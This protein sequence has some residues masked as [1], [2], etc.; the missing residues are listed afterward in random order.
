MRAVDDEPVQIWLPGQPVPPEFV[1][2]ANEPDWLVIAH[3]DQFESAIE[4][5]VLGVDKT[6]FITIVG[7]TR[8]FD[9]SIVVER[10]PAHPGLVDDFVLMRIDTLDVVVRAGRR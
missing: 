7:T 3:Q 8:R 6:Q 9:L 1:T 2:A 4:T 5:H 10:Q